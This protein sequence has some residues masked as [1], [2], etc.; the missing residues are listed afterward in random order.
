MLDTW[1]S[2]WLWPFSTLGWPDETPDVDAFY[3]GAALSTAPEI[4]FFWVARMIMAGYEFMG[5][6]P[7]EQV[8][9]HGTVRDKKGRKMSKSLGN[10]IDPLEVVEL[11]GADALRFTLISAAA[12]G[13]D[14]YL[15]HEDLESTFAPGRNFANKVWNAGRFALMNLGDGPIAPIESVVDQLEPADRWILTRLGEATRQI[16]VELG[17]FRLKEVADLVYHFFWGSFADWYLELIK[18]RMAEGADPVRR[19]TARST[20]LHVLDQTLR[21]LHPLIPFVT[22]ALFER[23]PTAEGAQ[24]PDALIIAPWP[25]PNEDL[26]D[27]DAA[28]AIASL[29]EV[30]VE[31]RRLRKEYGIKE[32]QAVS[33]ELRG[34]TP[35]LRAV[36]EAERSAVERLAWVTLEYREAESA[37]EGVGAHSVLPGGVELFVPLEGVID[38]EQERTRLAGEIERLEKQRSGVRGKLANANFVERAP[39]AVV[40]GER[41]KAVRLEDQI[42]KLKEKMEGLGGP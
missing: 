26:E 41:D 14:I 13:T 16:D 27:A 5:D 7:F 40:Q 28:S 30:V 36:L 9:L 2:S 10:G 35:G 24:R 8:Y 39:E 20:L 23:L 38:I 17:R 29:Q 11:F 18:P 22:E 34:W 42:G 3:P 31:A 32:G 25:T 15:D 1:F 19:E 6:A 21:L 4:L 37:T 33:L 12:V